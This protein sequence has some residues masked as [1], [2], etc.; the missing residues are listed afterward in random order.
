MIT[1]KN[2][3]PAMTHPYSS[4]WRQ[5]KTENILIDDTHAIMS[6]KDFDQLKDYSMSIPTGV[7]DGKMWKRLAARGWLLCWYGPSEKEN[8]CSIN[9][10]FIII[11]EG[12]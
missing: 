11:E 8:Q 7:Y 1:D 12:A 2:I 3:I 5:P 4:G 10:R 9:N 6:E